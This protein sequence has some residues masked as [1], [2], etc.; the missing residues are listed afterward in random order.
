MTNLTP[1]LIYVIVVTF[2]PGPN[3]IMSMVNG[4]RYG[5]KKMLRFLAGIV[6][7]FFIVMFISGLLN[8]A[9]TN[10]IPD[11]GHWLKI[12]GALYMLYLAYHVLRSGPIE[13][14]PEKGSIN[15]FK[16]GFTMQFL[17]IKAI[18]FGVS[19]Y[20]L[21]IIDLYKSPWMI[22]LFALFLALNALAATSAW[23][24]GGNLFRNVGQKHYRI[25][26]FVMAGLLIYTAI[27]GLLG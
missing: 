13:E 9:L 14:N 1:F 4:M 5:Y 23:A 25:V 2:T 20:S 26:N 24:L 7:G 16:F 21:F 10:L 18:L 11:S 22:F 3:N 15:S 12:L 19:V 8:V 27:S 17:N 6:T